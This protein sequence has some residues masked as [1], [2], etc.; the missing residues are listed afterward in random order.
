MIQ[1]TIKINDT[2]KLVIEQKDSITIEEALATATILKNVVKS[3]DGM[4][5]ISNEI[6]KDNLLDIKSDDNVVS[7][8]K[9]ISDEEFVR[10]Y[11]GC[12]NI[13]EKKILAKELGIKFRSIKQKMYMLKRNNNK[14]L[15]NTSK[16]IEMP[17]IITGNLSLNLEQKKEFY[18]LYKNSKDRSKLA[19]QFSI[20]PAKI[21]KLAWNMGRVLKANK[22]I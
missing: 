11:K 4:N 7:K 12:K 14:V 19:R 10:R 8:R 21:S 9:V 15:N 3:F 18:D 5:S 20:D 13:E 1:Q 6:K 2:I 22:L 16:K 17:K